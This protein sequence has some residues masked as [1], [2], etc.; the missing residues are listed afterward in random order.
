[1]NK[2]FEI[3][4]E[5]PLFTGVSPRDIESMLRCMGAS[6]RQYVKD[7]AILSEGDPAEYI[8]IVL[9]G[10]VRIMRTDIFGNRSILA[11]AGPM[12]MFGEALACADTAVMPVDVVAAE[13][14]TA[15]LINAARIARTC[16]SACVFHSR[17]IAN[18][19]HIVASKNIMMNSKLEVTSKRST[20]DKLLTYLMIQAKTSGS[21]SFTIP[22]DRQELADYLEVDRSGLSAEI[23][24]LRRE[25]VIE[26]TRS[27]FTILRDV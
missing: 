2:Y 24:R 20:R 3:L 12:D 9:S 23:S 21:D 7:K 26:S 14:T 16:A 17:M 22:F 4:T 13:D 25:G 8:G 19:L 1:M 10:S 15:I 5:C 18:L 6:V 27:R 11:K